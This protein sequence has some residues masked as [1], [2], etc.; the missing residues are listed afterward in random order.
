[1]PQEAGINAPMPVSTTSHLPCPPPRMPPAARIA[2]TLLLA[3]IL[4]PAAALLTSASRDLD[5][6][7]QALADPYTWRILRFTIWQAA[8]STFLSLLFA[9]PVARAIARRGTFA[10]RGALLRLLALPL[11]LPQLIAAFGI[12]AVW[13]AGGWLARFFDEGRWPGIYGLSGILLA[14]VFFNMPL[15]ARVLAQALQRLPAEYWR[16]AAQMNMPPTAI[17]RLIE[18]PALRSV[19]PGLATLIF[20]LCATSFTIVLVLGG[21]PAATT[22]EVAIYEALRYEF[23]PPRAVALAA[24]QLLLLLALN[25]LLRRFSGPDAALTGAMLHPVPHPARHQPRARLTDAFWLM[26]ATLFT[27][28]PLAGIILQGL[29]AS[30][31]RLLGDA[32]VRQAILT[33][34]C[35]APPAAF[36]AL[37]L[38]LALLSIWHTPRGNPPSPR[39]QATAEMLSALALITPPLL[40]A[41]GWFLLLHQ[42]GFTPGLGQ[43]ALPAAIVVI[44]L[45]A[46][47]ALPFCWRIL[48]P[49]MRELAQ[50]QGPLAAHLG[51]SGCARLHLLLWPRLR[52]PLGLAL[53]LALA[54]SLGD[55]GAIALFGSERLTTLPLLL[56]QK[57]GSYR[58]TDAAALALLLLM[59]IAALMALAE[60][61]AARGEPRS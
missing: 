42:A 23:D 5:G 27:A 9:I 22:L 45:N 51:I 57:L 37:G 25:A 12:L 14:H 15:A 35:I 41:A 50:A 59:L 33:S 30:P 53:A 2:A 61:L 7:L 38:T 11:A 32:Q 16:L 52:R 19:L 28:A 40:L 48:Q 13:G 4:L 10:G 21:G 18:W 44:V 56:Y 39:W 55:L 20:L 34:L 47:M 58:T 31:W 8:L 49:A 6:A 43:G 60:H 54:L 26:A 29:A 46:L 36:A 3:L 1:M 24:L 17:W